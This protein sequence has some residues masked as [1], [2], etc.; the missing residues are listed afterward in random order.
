MVS[1]SSPLA[2]S[3]IFVGKLCSVNIDFERIKI[4]THREFRESL[5]APFLLAHEGN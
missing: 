3:F 1:H 2:A 5:I 4:G